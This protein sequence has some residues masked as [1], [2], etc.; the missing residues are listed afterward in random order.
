MASKGRKRLRSKPVDSR[1]KWDAMSWKKV[2]TESLDLGDQ[3]GEGGS[4]FFE[5]EEL[6]GNAYKLQRAGGAGASMSYTIESVDV[7]DVPQSDD[8]KGMKT[9]TKMKK[10][11]NNN[12]T[13]NSVDF[14][15]STPTSTTSSESGKE[16]DKEAEKE[17]QTTKKKKKKAKLGTAKFDSANVQDLV[18]SKEDKALFNHK[19]KG[20]IQKDRVYI[21][22]APEYS[23]WAGI[24]LNKLL[25]NSLNGL[26]FTVPTPI[27]SAAIPSI[28]STGNDVIGA[29]ETGSGKTLAFSLPMLHSLLDDFEMVEKRRKDENIHCPYAL[30]IVPTRELAMQINSVMKEVC[31]KFRSSHRIEIVTVVGGLSEHKQRRQLDGRPIHVLI[32][33]PGRLCELIQD[34]TIPA[35]QNMSAIRFIIVDEADRIVEEGHFPELHRLFSRIVD[36]EAKVV[37]GEDPRDVSK[38]VTS[39]AD[40]HD[41]NTMENDDGE[42]EE[43]YDNDATY[44]DGELEDMYNLD[45]E[46]PKFMKMPT[47]EELEEA[48]KNTPAI[49]LDELDIKPDTYQGKVSK[50]NKKFESIGKVVELR[51]E[52]KSKRQTLLF[53]ATALRILALQDVKPHEKKKRKKLKSTLK[54]DVADKLPYH[55]Q[56]LLSLVAIQSDVELID[57][58]SSSGNTDTSTSSK[59]NKSKNSEDDVDGDGMGSILPSLPKTLSHFQINVPAEEKDLFAYYYLQKNPNHRTLLFVNSIK[60]ARRVDGFLRALGLNCRAIHAQLQQRQ[61]IRALEAFQASPCGILVATDVAA[62]GLDVSRIS[63]V[64]HYDVARSAQVYI[65]R[66]G[67]TARANQKGVSISMVAPDDSPFHMSICKTIGIEAMD[68]YSV[69]SGVVQ[70]LRKRTVLAKKIFT[71]SFV[72]SQKLKD[73]SWVTQNATEADLELDDYMIDEEGTKNAQD[74]QSKLSKKELERARFELKQMLDTPVEIANA[75]VSQRRKGFVVF[76]PFSNK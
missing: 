42:E 72:N 39:D 12:K 45:Y 66:S 47:E 23:N 60:T 17:K 75:G 41:N 73:S 21:I 30:V 2:D 52:E 38:K 67:R 44:D 1:K 29:A 13:D 48:R 3:D 10:K 40:F 32:A 51:K 4:I 33:T 35:F 46:L 20:G 7:N 50:K 27:Q 69:D 64:V 57:I 22:P 59:K 31:K 34:E 15:G 70:T 61:R 9:T 14:L 76:N 16:A 55:L 18:L 71:Q 68:I 26:G 8:K 49:P 62:R 24:R 58:T 25:T 28:L 19:E 5:L 56:E 74:V 43:E 54:K 65:H 11:N 53:S 36:H 37:R 63:S 6:D